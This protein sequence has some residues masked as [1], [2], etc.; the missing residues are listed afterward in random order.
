MSIIIINLVRDITKSD[1]GQKI[2]CGERE[3]HDLIQTETNHIKCS[4]EEKL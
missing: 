4:T 3:E 1:E 2:S